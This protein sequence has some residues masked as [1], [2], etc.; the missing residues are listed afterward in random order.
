MPK[1]RGLY[2]GCQF[3]QKHGPFVI[4]N[5]RGREAFIDVGIQ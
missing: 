4:L 1:S 3:Y 2:P 5:I